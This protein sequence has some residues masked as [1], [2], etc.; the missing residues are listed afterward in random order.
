MGQINNPINK[1]QSDILL[2]SPD[3]I[4][5]AGLSNPQYNKLIETIRKRF[6]KTRSLTAREIHEYWEVR[7]CLSVDDGL[8]LPDQRIVIPTSQCAKVLHCL[9]S[10]HQGEVSMKARANESVYWPRMNASIRNIRANCMVCSK[11]APSQ[12][13][14]PIT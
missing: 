1:I 13:K 12:P 11:I 9:H 5:A 3:L 14:E 8:V 2:T 10:T 4:H 7:H 6:P